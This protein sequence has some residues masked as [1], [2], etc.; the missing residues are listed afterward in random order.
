MRGHLPQFLQVE[1]DHIHEEES[2]I[3]VREDEEGLVSLMGE[4][5]I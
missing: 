5:D 1:P 3:V 4:Q 2:L